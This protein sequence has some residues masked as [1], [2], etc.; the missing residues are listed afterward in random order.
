MH[1]PTGL[2]N[3]SSDPEP[4]YFQLTFEDS[5][6]KAPSATGSLDMRLLFPSATIEKLD[7]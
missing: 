4:A 6:N 5:D 7:D 1:L 3:D 2:F